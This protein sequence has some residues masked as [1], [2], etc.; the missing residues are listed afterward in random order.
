MNLIT[1]SCIFPNFVLQYT[2][3]TFTYNFR[4]RFTSRRKKALETINIVN[5]I[6]ATVV[7]I[8]LSIM[9]FHIINLPY[10]C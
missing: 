1:L 6:Y 7:K 3:K 5:V 10:G 2:L 4:P 9:L 8:F